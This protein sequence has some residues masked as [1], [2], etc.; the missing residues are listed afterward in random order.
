M[1]VGASSSASGPVRP[2][3]MTTAMRAVQRE[4]GDRS[5]L[6]VA[7]ARAGRIEREWTLENGSVTF[8]R[9]DD[10]D[11]VV[12]GHASDR[13]TLVRIE[14]GVMTLAIPAGASGRVQL[15]GVARDVVELA[16]SAISLDASARG[17]IVLGG[18]GDEAVSILFQ[19]VASLPK[20]TR[21][22]LPAA[23]RGGLFDRV[24]WL[25]TA[26]AAASFMAHLAFVV[27]M[28]NADWPVPP[29]LATI[30]DR[31]AEIVFAD[32]P[33]PPMPELTD[34]T[35]PALPSTPTD[36]S[37]SPT[38]S[39]DPDP[40]PRPSHPSTP[41]APR[42]E[43]APQ[44]AAQQAFDAVD[45]LII[46]AGSD[47]LR[48]AIDDVLRTGQPTPDAADVFALADDGT[49]VAT[50]DH[51]QMHSGQAPGTPDF[52]PR[53]IGT[54]PGERPEGE[55]LVETDPH[56]GHVTVDTIVDPID[57]GI[58]DDAMLRRALR[59]HMGAIQRC[60]ETEL[61]RTPGLAGRIS[62]SMQVETAGN[63]SHVQAVD[64]TVGSRGLTECVINNVR[65]IHLA[66]GP[67]EPVTVE[68]P[69]VFAPQ[70]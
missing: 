25:F 22:E 31:A 40:S 63:L 8:G 70:D 65:S 19:R 64:D 47:E 33:M 57:P 68:Y 49:Q 37:P 7:I 15:S 38:P 41:S 30:P 44:F 1:R 67:S 3:A 26:L 58:F 45:Q 54:R 32:V 53:H 18:V 20:R 21:P 29:S 9:G 17:R 42:P 52:G 35:D 48:G 59:S 43:V 10:S 61:T 46:G 34:P 16:G 4:S 27:G 14:D 51:V 5:A 36:P 56:P 23:V 6:R 55:H 60:Y 62:L 39:H 2:G 50:A 24:D 11:V 28:S 13:A 69:I 66:S 12:P